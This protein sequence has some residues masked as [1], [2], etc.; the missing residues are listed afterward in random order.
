MQALYQAVV[1][2]D[3]VARA[4]RQLSDQKENR[5]VNRVD[6]I[7]FQKAASGIWGRRELLDRWI[8]EASKNWSLDRCPIVDHNILR[9]GVYELLEEQEIP[10]EII[11]NEAV[12]LSKRFGG[13]NSG[14]FVNGVLDKI[15]ERI[16]KE[17]E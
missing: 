9:L 5:D 6:L 3:E 13:E 15:A 14:Q 8:V 12:E 2:G 1:S 11:L 10:M 16:R 7:Y 17:K 4:V